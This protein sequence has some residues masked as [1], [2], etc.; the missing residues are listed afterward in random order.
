MRHPQIL[1]KERAQLLVIDVQDKLVNAMAARTEVVA[2]TK[3]LILASK[4]MH[5]PVFYTEQYPRGLGNTITEIKEAL[6]QQSP[7]EKVSFSCCSLANLNDSLSSTGRRQII[8]AG[9]EAHVCVQQTALDLMAKDYIVYVAAD[10]TCSRREFDYSIALERLKEAGTII[11][12]TESIIFELLEQAG[13]P[14]FKELLQII[15]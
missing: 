10:A 9:V 6:G 4:K 13:T 2:N 7:F 11:T 14:L 1:T 8:L 12:T 3:K 5:I 15:K